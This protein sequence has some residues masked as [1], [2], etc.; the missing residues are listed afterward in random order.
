MINETKLKTFQKMNKQSD[1]M[2]V[3]RTLSTAIEFSFSK[4]GKKNE[5]PN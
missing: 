2:G 1:V 5:V 3:I 4:K